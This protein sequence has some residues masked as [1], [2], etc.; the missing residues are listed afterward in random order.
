MLR[1]LILNDKVQRSGKV[2]EKEKAEMMEKG[3]KAERVC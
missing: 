3:R 2:E 1:R